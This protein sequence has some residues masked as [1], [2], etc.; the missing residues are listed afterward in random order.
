MS[1]LAVGLADSAQTLA[2]LTPTPWP[3]RE[4]QGRFMPAFQVE[5]GVVSG[6]D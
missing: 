3:F 2:I 1:C 6:L 5:G 4:R